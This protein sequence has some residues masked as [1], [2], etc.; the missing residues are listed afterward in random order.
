MDQDDLPRRYNGMK[1][2][3]PTGPRWPQSGVG[4]FPG[5]PYLADDGFFGAYWQEHWYQDYGA[6]ALTG[7]NYTGD[8]MEVLRK[9]HH[10]R[11]QIVE[12]VNGWMVETFRLD[13]PKARTLWGLKTRVAAK[14]C[15]VNL[16]IWLNRIFGRV[17]LAFTT[18]FSC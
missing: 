7:K 6:M 10:S 1:Y 17:G 11:R 18:L 16:R 13:F 9:Q 5:V 2:I 14:V 3:G 12:T 15:G 8:R 4:E